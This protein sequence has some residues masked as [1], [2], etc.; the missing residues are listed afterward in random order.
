VPSGVTEVSV[1]EKWRPEK[2]EKT[3]EK[4]ETKK[5]VKNP[6]LRRK[7]WY[8]LREKTKEV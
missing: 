1:L 2:L 8:N 5:R 6:I 7:I 3:E 4:R